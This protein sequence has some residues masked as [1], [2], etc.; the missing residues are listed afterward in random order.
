MPTQLGAGPGRVASRL[1]IF[2]GAAGLLW[3]A[4]HGLGLLDQSG[5]LTKVLGALMAVVATIV[6]LRFWRP[7]PVW[8]WRFVLAAF[9]LFALELTLKLVLD[10][11]SG[12]LSIADLVALSAYI[13]LAIGVAG[14]AGVGRGE[15]DDLDAVL[16]AVIAALAV[17]SVVWVSFVMPFLAQDSASASWS[18]IPSGRCSSSPWVPGSCSGRARA[19][20]RP[21]SSASSR[22]W[23]SSSAT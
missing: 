16:D 13:V 19:P 9:G 1:W 22:C 6:G 11:D 14:V 10:S 17:L 18:P 20:C 2:V 21:C 7:K 3:A 15:R 12:T 23:P 8:P 4:L 5:S